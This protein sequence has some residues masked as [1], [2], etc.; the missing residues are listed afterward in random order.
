MF[1]P[2][3]KFLPLALVTTLGLS[4][5][6]GS[7]SDI[8]GNNNNNGNNNGSNE[9]EWVAGQFTPYRDLAQECSSTNGIAEKLWMRSWSNDTYLWYDE[10]IDRDPANF[11]IEDYFNVLITNELSESG[12]RKDNFHFSM[13]TDEWQQLN[14]SGASFGYG[15]NYSLRNASA[16]TSRQ[17]TVTFTDPSTPAATANVSRGAVL[18]EIDGVNVASAATQAEIDIL[19]AGLFP[20]DNGKQTE[21]VVRDLGSSQLR[22]VNLTAQTVIATPVQNTKTIQTTSGKVGY[23]QFNTHIATA[24]RGLY[25]AF[26]TLANEGVDDLVI[27]LR[28]NGG[29][30]LAIA[31]QMGYMVA[32]EQATTGKT[33]EQMRF[34]D[35][36]PNSDPVTGATLEPT[37]FIPISLGYNEDLLGRGVALPSLNLDRVFVLTTDSTCSASEAFMNGLRGIDIEV[38][39]I[40]DTTCG[41]PYGFYPTDNCDTTYF[42]I[43]F[44]GENQKGFGD[45]SDGFMPSMNPVISSQV[46]GCVVEDD[47]NHAL[48]DSSEGLLS[49]ALH[50]R[51][52]GSC[53]AVAQSKALAAPAVPFDDPG[54]MLE[55]TRKQSLWRNN[56]ILTDINGAQ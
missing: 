15:M 1:S 18:V 46:Q 27:D 20:T 53:P 52:N 12:N 17:V 56:R 35:K 2:K 40:G 47:L 24:E 45:Y 5:C 29:G 49:A 41:K 36:Y 37:P 54:Y 6:G 43:Q 8:S 32:G 25:D 31:S 28:Y 51:A 50:Y 23:L 39:Q 9:F 26:T 4:A 10:I 7:S 33:F 3:L 55:D 16:T 44:R 11:S 42:T 34:N 14:Q 30:L 13:P 38:I 19:N 21:F 22:T 48:G